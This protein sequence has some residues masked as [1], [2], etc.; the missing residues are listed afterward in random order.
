[1]NR[2][3]HLV[4]H[5]NEFNEIDSYSQ[6]MLETIEPINNKEEVFTAMR[7]LEVLYRNGVLKPDSKVVKADLGY[8]TLVSM[9]ATQV[10]TPTWHFVV[11][12]NG[13]QEN[14]LVNAVEGQIIQA[15][16]SPDKKLME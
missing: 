5:I 14:L 16:A 9:E 7:A 11:E 10:L 6:T 8:H 3:A 13:E 1:M 15:N 2:S 4:F 12:H